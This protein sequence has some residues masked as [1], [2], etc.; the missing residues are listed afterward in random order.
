MTHLSDIDMAFD[1]LEEGAD[2]V[3]GPAEDGGLST[4]NEPY[5]SRGF[6]KGLGYLCS[7]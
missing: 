4:G 3:I 5:D 6:Q 7:I 2:A 1:H